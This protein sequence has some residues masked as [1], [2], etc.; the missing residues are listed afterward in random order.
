MWEFIT[1]LFDSSDFCNKYGC[2][3]W[4]D[5][6]IFLHNLGDVTIG[7]AYLAIPIV[8]IYILTRKNKP[9]FP[10][11]W[12]MYGLFITFCGLTHLVEAYSYHCP[13]YRFVGLMKI[14]TAAVSWLTVLG[15]AKVLPFALKLRTPR[16]LESL[17]NQR[18]QE[19]Q[20]ANDELQTR[21]DKE[22]QLTAQLEQRKV[23][24]LEQDKQRTQFLAM[25]A[26]ELRNPLAPIRTSM[27]VIR[28]RYSHAL[29]GKFNELDDIIS[30]QLSHMSRM[31]DDLLDVARITHGKIKLVMERVHVAKAV[32][33]AIDSL[34]ST[35]HVQDRKITV[36]VPPDAFVRADPTRLEQIIVNLV[37]NSTK[38]SEPDGEI[39]LCV[40]CEAG[41]VVIEVCDNGCGIDKEVLPHIFDLFC[42]GDKSLERTKGGLGIGLTIVKKLVDLHGASIEVETELDVGTKFR[43]T[44]AC[45][46][47][48][49]VKMMK[50]KAIGC[51][52]RL[53][54]V[55]D[56]VDSA[57]SLAYLFEQ[58][59]HDI[60]VCHD[61]N[62]AVV[63]ANLFDPDVVILDIGI[64]GLNG[65][66]VA[67]A[68]RSSTVTEKVKIIVVSGYSRDEDRAEAK[69]AGVD[70]YLVKPAD[71]QTLRDAVLNTA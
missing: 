36:T 68:L 6:L 30:R 14:L 34:K 50:P 17:V 28:E 44:F 46:S 15:L 5:S 69:K 49:E 1:K 45:A 10:H 23:E 11:L 19:L 16:E 33:S 43:V 64:P 8:M 22:Q 26:H 52:K 37:G 41:K 2:R 24:L 67:R 51:R 65:F 58:E 38:Y 39:N 55:E 40:F 3:G 12:W 9:P 29:D 31:I 7:L 57:T 61:G 27:H 48:D 47:D 4:D 21:I 54:I 56:N 66:E 35:Y 63:T 53:L 13:I 18:T 60:R 62:T 32:A 59:D 71:I 20:K 25:L 70:V 42:Q